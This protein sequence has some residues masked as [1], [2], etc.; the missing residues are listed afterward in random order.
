VRGAV[1]L[2][3][4]YNELTAPDFEP[5]IAR[6]VWDNISGSPDP[7]RPAE[8]E[9]V[10]DT[11]GWFP[12]KLWSI[13]RF[14]DQ[15][16][17]VIIAGQY[18][19]TNLVERLYTN[20]QF[21]FF[22]ADANS[23]D[24]APPSILYA[25]ARESN[26][27]IEFLVSAFDEEPG[28]IQVWATYQ[29]GSGW[30]SVPLIQQANGAWSAFVAGLEKDTPFFV[31]ACDTSG[32]CSTKMDSNDYLVG[33]PPP[34]FVNRVGEEHTFT[35]GV[36]KDP[37]TCTEDGLTPGSCLIP[38]EGIIPT[39]SLIDANGAPVTGWYGTCLDGTG[40]D[41]TCTVIINSNQP[42][43][44]SVSASAEIQVLTKVLQRSTDGQIGNSLDATKVYVDASLSL[45]STSPG[46]LEVNNTFTL[47]ATLLKVLGDGGEPVPAVGETVN[48][49][50][51]PENGVDIQNVV[52]NCAD[53]EQGTDANGQ[54]TVSFTSPTPG[55]VTA[56]ANA[57]LDADGE[58]GFLYL[59][60]G[61]VTLGGGTGATLTLTRRA[62]TRCSATWTG[63]RPNRTTGAC[64]WS[65]C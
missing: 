44:I 27:G 9:P 47:T 60:G 10:F 39:V 22:E 17:L 6:P 25:A 38:A 28:L 52:D 56:T 29:N 62:V 40:P 46:L 32:N 5:L 16:Q 63:R 24:Y 50:L 58:A 51:T 54:C 36:W 14:G 15:D 42:G 11:P 13:N 53:P 8:T 55:L 41:G 64:G 31:Q 7:D 20:M 37:G 4:T 65:A 3:A 34:Q 26:G 30:I 18:N 61:L 33:S 48:V 35:I 59:D 12:T 45:L 49:L 2:G 19:Y 1:L 23:V 43:P 21:Q 57:T